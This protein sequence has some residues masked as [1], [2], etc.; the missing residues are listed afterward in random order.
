MI[1]CKSA[2]SCGTDPSRSRYTHTHTFHTSCDTHAQL[3]TYWTNWAPGEPSLGQ[4]KDCVSVNHTVVN[5]TI[6]DARWYTRRCD[7]KHMYACQKH[8]FDSN[9]SE[10]ARAHTH[11]HL[12][13]MQTAC[14]AAT[15]LWPW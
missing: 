12:A 4:D 11:T 10:C 3:D 8:A 5:G 6:T 9:R 7:E 15:G 13:H 1:A 14:R 2:T